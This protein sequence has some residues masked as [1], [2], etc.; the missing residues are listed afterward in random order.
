MKT[1]MQAP[2]TQAPLTSE[3]LSAKTEAEE[4]E[5]A[6]RINMFSNISP[7]ELNEIQKSVIATLMKANRMFS[8]LANIKDALSTEDIDSDRRLREFIKLKALI[9][10]SAAALAKNREEGSIALGLKSESLQSK[11]REIERAFVDKT[12]SFINV[13][14]SGIASMLKLKVLKEVNNYITDIITAI[15]SVQVFETFEDRQEFYNNLEQG[16]AVQKMRLREELELFPKDFQDVVLDAFRIFEKIIFYNGRIPIAAKNVSQGYKKNE[17]QLKKL[18]DQMNQNLKISDQVKEK[19]GS[20]VELTTFIKGIEELGLKQRGKLLNIADQALS[21]S[22][23]ILQVQEKPQEPSPQEPSPQKPESVPL[24]E[25]SAIEKLKPYIQDI[26]DQLKIRIEIGNVSALSQEEAAYLPVQNTAAE[27]GVDKSSSLWTG[28]VDSI[29][30]IKET[31]IK[32]ARYYSL[33]IEASKNENT[34]TPDKRIQIIKMLAMALEKIDKFIDNLKISKLGQ[35]QI[36]SSFADLIN[37]NIESY[38]ERLK[39]F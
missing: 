34:N 31:V 19:L 36:E 39:K 2:L 13:Q 22:E 37:T 4:K 9:D 18:I 14:A 1:A 11:I 7:N 25:S 12:L 26:F 3:E 21:E 6:R 35:T 33:G 38:R 8:K 24:D 10:D 28:L 29:V 17:E 23:A 20:D 5:V 27:L 15:E 16:I 30:K 32:L